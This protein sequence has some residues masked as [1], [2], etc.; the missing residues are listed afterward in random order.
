MLIP[1][2]KVKVDYSENGA[3]PLLTSLILTVHD[4]EKSANFGLLR[5]DGTFV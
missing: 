1:I 2:Q 5:I 3:R 4:Q